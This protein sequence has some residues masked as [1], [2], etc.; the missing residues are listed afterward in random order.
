MIALPNASQK[1]ARVL[2]SRLA[3]GAAVLVMF[4]C[5]AN[6]LISFPIDKAV[7]FLV[8]VTIL[9]TS[10]REPFFRPAELVLIGMLIVLPVLSS[11]ANLVFKPMIFFPFLGFSFAVVLSRRP[12]LVLGPLYY[13]LIFHIALGLV[14]VALAFA[15]FNNQY[16]WSLEEKGLPFVYSAMGFTATVQTFGTLCMLWLII[17]YVRK[18]F[19]GV[20]RLDWFFFVINTLGVLSTLNRSTFLFWIII[21]FFKMRR[22]FT[23]ILVVIAV[24]VVRFWHE[25]IT[26]LGNP[27]SIDARS[28]LLEGFN[29]SFWG[30]HSIPVYIFGKGNNQLTEAVA[31]KTKW[32]YRLD[33]ENGYAMLL[34][35]YGFLGLF[36]YIGIASF[37]VAAF[38]R[39]RRFAEAFIMFFFLFVSPY[40][41]Q[42]FV[43]MSFY[44]FLS[45]MLIIFRIYRGDNEFIHKPL[46]I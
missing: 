16:A 4:L 46:T 6:R 22:F 23:V 32:D 30:S 11:M 39:I 2:F 20:S 31:A 26:F 40:I 19:Y 10:P 9:F 34:H 12:N 1:I 13:A 17:F 41:T 8:L 43:S 25:V 7:M 45:T 42:E 3:G 21:L 5:T 15:G 38:I 28:E 44:L 14:F 35:T 24:F 36:V 29:I 18:S 37:F 27:A 33:I